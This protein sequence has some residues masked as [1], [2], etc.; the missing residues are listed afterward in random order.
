MAND[1]F[2]SFRKSF[3]LISS[4]ENKILW[5]LDFNGSIQEV[6]VYIDFFVQ[7]KRERVKFDDRLVTWVESNGNRNL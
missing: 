6:Y 1:I 3:T 5:G 4:V 2:S 7:S